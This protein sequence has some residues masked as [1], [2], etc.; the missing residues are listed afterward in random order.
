M[1]FQLDNIS[2]TDT[3]GKKT[4][5]KTSFL[6]K[7]ITLFGTGFSNKVKEEFYMQLGV[8]LRAGITLKD[9]LELVQNATKKKQH[10]HKLN[11]IYTDIIGGLSLS[12]AVSKHNAF[13]DYEYYSLKIGE[14][15]GT[16]MQVTEQLGVFYGR[17]NE[18]RR[19]L[20]SALTY[21]FIILTTAVL[22][23]VFM[24]QYVVP[25]F[26]DIFEQ[27]NVELPAITKFIISISGFMKT[28]GWLL[29][30]ILLIAIASRTFFNKKPWYRRIK[31]RFIL[32][33]P[34]I[35]HFVM[36]VYLS[37]FTQA[38]F[39]LTSSKV[40]VVNSI[41]LVK[42]MINFYPLQSALNDVEKSILRGLSLSESLKSH[43][44]FD[45]KMIAL[46]RVAE[47]TNQNEFVFERLNIQYNTEVAQRSRQL[48]TIMEPVIIMIVG[49]LVGVILIAMYLPMFKLSSVLG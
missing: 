27:Q 3:S 37:Q 13:T 15:T 7:E 46:V 12:E 41:Q 44:I 20:I 42:Q 21:P 48:S 47:E 24:L 6:Q 49:V 43:K 40:P 36:T 18:Q 4:V 25:M 8:L 33:L 5:K 32:R 17:K 45:D 11:M 10:K 22:V 14:E 26:Q 31:D 29:L 39:L 16:L 28:Y 2:K 34:F 1:A 23:V 9:A 19:N 35:G 38:V 30:V